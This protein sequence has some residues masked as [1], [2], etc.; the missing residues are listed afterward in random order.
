MLCKC[1]WIVLYIVHFTAFCLGDRFYPDTVYYNDY[2]AW[3]VSKSSRFG[4]LGGVTVKASD[5]R[6]SGG[7]FHIPGRGVVKVGQPSIP[8]G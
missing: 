3:A 4:C 7:G 5:F 2:V 1:H 6:S 8:L